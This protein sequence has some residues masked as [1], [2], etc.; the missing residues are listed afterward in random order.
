MSEKKGKLVLFQSK[1]IRRL[2]HDDAWLFSV[3]DVV[4]ALTDSVNPRDYWYKMKVRVKGEEGFEPST[5]CRQLKMKAPDRKNRLT[6]CSNTE[7]ILR[8]IQS[9]PSPKAEPFKRWL[10]KVGSERIQEIEN[11]E[12]AQERMKAIYEQKGYPSDWIDKRLRSMAIR[13][14]LT[15]EWKERGI[16]E[17]RDF[18]ILTA[19]ISK[20]TFGVTPSEYKKA[21]ETA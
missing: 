15:D 14:N 10:A 13:Q 11:P 17:H 12:L 21:K 6:D 7:G 20:A 1:E 4:A 3:I 9:I 18:A 19:E 2:W 8:I 5:V 16:Q